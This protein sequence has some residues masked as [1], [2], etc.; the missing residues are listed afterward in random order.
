MTSHIAD[1][2][3]AELDIAMDRSKSPS[4]VSVNGTEMYFE[5]ES[6]AVFAYLA[7]RG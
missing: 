3:I 5:T 4:T 6:D 1:K 2:R 7:G